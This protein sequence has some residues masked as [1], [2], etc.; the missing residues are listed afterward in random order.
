VQ[1]RCKICSSDVNVNTK[2][3]KKIRSYFLPH[4]CVTDPEGGPFFVTNSYLT[5]NLMLGIWNSNTHNRVFRTTPLDP[6]WIQINPINL[7]HQ[8]LHPIMSS[9]LSLSPQMVAS[10]QIFGLNSVFYTDKLFPILKST[11]H[12]N[13]SQVVEYLLLQ[14]EAHFNR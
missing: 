4:N 3:N 6:I 2:L 11:H 13:S 14:S 8:S 5:V 1:T 7:Y 10:L 12:Y 9:H